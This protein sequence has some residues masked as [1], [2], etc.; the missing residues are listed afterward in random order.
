MATSFGAL[1][2]DF[3]VN[4]KLALKLD[5]PGDR[6]TILHLF[7]QVR[8]A[9]PTMSR[10]RRYNNELALESSRRD[11]SYRWLAIRRNSIRTGNVNPETMEQA[12]Q[13]HKRILELAPYHMT[14]SPLDLDYI[15]L[16]FGFEL[17][18]KANHDEVVFEALI[19]DAPVANLVK[20]PNAEHPRILD[21]Q[22]IFGI[23]LSKSGNLQAYFEVK[24]RT[25]SRR[26]RTSRT[27]NEPIGLLLTVRKYGPVQRLDDLQEE[28]EVLRQH[29]ETLATERL[30]PLMLT[31]ISRQITSSSA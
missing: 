11:P 23:S 1:C 13:F 20:M 9:D 10:F 6:E 22:P 7:E 18:C 14:I 24:T 25:R 28:F 17:E 27:R 29:C 30:V 21:V 12:F 15:E 3:Y 8:K 26:G 5:L 19:G 31:P 16:L 4:Q 2:T